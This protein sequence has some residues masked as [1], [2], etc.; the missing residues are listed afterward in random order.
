MRGRDLTITPPAEL[1]ELPTPTLLDSL[2][3]PY[4]P[5]ALR[6]KMGRDKRFHFVRTQPI[7]FSAVKQALRQQQTPFTVVFEE[8]PTLPF[9][10]ALAIEPRPYQEDALTAW[11]AQ[12]SA[13]VV[14]LPTGAGKTFVA[15]MAIVETGLWTL[16][17]VPTIDLLQQWRTALATAL[18]LNID[19]IGTFGGG[20]KELKPITI[21][22]YDSAA[23]YPRELSRFGLL[24]FDECHHLPAP[25][26]RLIAESAFSPLRLGLSATPERSDMAHVELDELIGPEVYRRSPA[27]LT[28]GRYLAQYQEKIIDIA[29]SG[30]D[31]IRY[32]EQRRIYSS[33]LRRRRIVIRSPEDFQQKLI[34]LSARDPEARTAM[35]AWREARQIAMNAPAKYS[36]I[37]RL[38]HKHAA[39]QVLLF[40]EYNPVVDEISRRFCLP[41]ITYKTPTEERRTILDRFRTGQYTKLVTGRVLNEGV[42]VP[43]CRV[44]IIVSGNS[45]KREYIQ[46]LGRILRPKEGEA[47]LYEL[48]TTGTTEEEMAKRRKE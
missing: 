11:L 18:S 10:T 4:L 22:T 34:F 15:A 31:E 13:G 38:L 14:V 29:L 41:S 42:D 28:E 5:K 23:L 39:D 46:R 30:E 19:D 2:F 37:E 40:S 48:V 3:G 43:D 7:H 26:Y 47:L 35:L 17:V 8:R 6:A 36:E 24:I 1:L 45:T 25:T 16:A 27:E 9:S 21:I 20:E 44:A 32:A 12:G 33:F